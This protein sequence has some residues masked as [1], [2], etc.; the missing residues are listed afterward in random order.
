MKIEIKDKLIGSVDKNN[1]A[2]ITYK[3]QFWD[4]DNNPMENQPVQVYEE[5]I[6]LYDTD[7]NIEGGADF[8]VVIDIIKETRKTL[9]FIVGNETRTKVFVLDI[10]DKKINAATE[11]QTQITT[12]N[13]ISSSKRFFSEHQIWLINKGDHE[14]LTDSTGNIISPNF[15]KHEIRDNRIIA[16]KEGTNTYQEAIVTKNNTLSS[17]YKFISID[18][19]KIKAFDRSRYAYIKEDGRVFGWYDYIT[20][21]G[22][23]T[24]ATNKD[25]NKKELEAIIYEDGTLSNWYDAIFTNN[26]DDILVVKNNLYGLLIGGRKEVGWYE[27]ISNNVENYEGK[28]FAIRRIPGAGYM[29]AA[30]NND[31]TLSKWTEY[32]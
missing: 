23:L 8:E 11:T 4:K 27:R 1:R 30:I 31:G 2:H 22:G 14:F 17:W 12:S 29:K 25:T 20:F 19:G 7:T 21:K 9:N 3:L 10:E 32:K 24:I 6:L 13:K 5:N 16:I 15:D 26:P 18:Q 28:W